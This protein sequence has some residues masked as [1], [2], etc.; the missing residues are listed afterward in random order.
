MFDVRGDLGPCSLGAVFGRLE[1][2]LKVQ[3]VESVAMYKIGT[4]AL[5]PCSRTRGI[6][7]W[8]GV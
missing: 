6:V 3:F 7:C 5:S 1:M 8:F 2:P 4:N